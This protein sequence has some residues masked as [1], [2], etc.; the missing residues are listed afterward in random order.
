M[1]DPNVSGSPTT[2]Q[3]REL[4]GY[5]KGQN[6]LRFTDGAPSTA[7]DLN[8]DALCAAVESLLEDRELLDAIEHELTYYGALRLYHDGV[9]DGLHYVRRDKGPI[10]EHAGDTLREALRKAVG[11]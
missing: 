2:E 3:L 5:V 9:E 10:T 1:T 6:T 4:V 7:V 11:A 8:V